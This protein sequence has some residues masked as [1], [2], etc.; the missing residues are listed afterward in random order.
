MEFKVTLELSRKT[1]GITEV[2][3]SFYLPGKSDTITINDKEIIIKGERSNRISFD[4]F[5]YNQ[6]N[7]IHRQF[8]KALLYL[9]FTRGNCFSIKK[10]IFEQGKKKIETK[11]IVKEELNHF[12]TK[13]IDSNH[14]LNKV[15]C[16]RIFDYCSTNKVN[17]YLH[18]L[19]WFVVGLNDNKFDSYWKS[20]NSIYRTISTKN[21]EKDQ[22]ADLKSFLINNWNRM[23]Y[24]NSYFST[25]TKDYIRSLSIREYVFSEFKKDENGYKAYHKMVC[26]FRDKR[27]VDLF[28]D[29][30]S[31]KEDGLRTYNLENTV[32]THIAQMISQNT[33]VNYDVVRFL[34]LKYG[35]YLRCKYF[36]A[37]K[38]YANLVVKE[39]MDIGNL[40]KITNCLKILLYDL[41]NCADLYV[42]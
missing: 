2:K 6:N 14:L 1:K 30:K 13:P 24:S 20:I 5:K 32:N 21:T 7:L 25:I 41:L 16:G 40:E 35:Y 18:A 31:Y 28:N 27:I 4:D 37:E 29:I 17:N 15:I 33:I 3:Q 34:I 42:S 38:D 8:L 10:I 26:S 23:S 11:E 22:L 19:S 9:Y 39:T 36:H 12:F